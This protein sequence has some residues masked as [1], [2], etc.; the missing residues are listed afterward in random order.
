MIRERASSD[1]ERESLLYAE[2]EEE[3]SIRMRYAMDDEVDDRLA[4][5]EGVHLKVR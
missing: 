3:R 5:Q 1:K 2:E 4:I